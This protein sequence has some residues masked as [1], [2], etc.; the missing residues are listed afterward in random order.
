MSHATIM[1]T[2]LM[3]RQS[4]SSISVS[5]ARVWTGLY[6]RNRRLCAL[7]SGRELRCKEKEMRRDNR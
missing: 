3:E 5:T 1:E 2:H 7:S 6:L 4:T